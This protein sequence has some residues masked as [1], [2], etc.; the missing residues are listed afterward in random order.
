M[1]LAALLVLAFM[2]GT[3]GCSAVNA[4]NA[5]RT[6]TLRPNSGGDVTQL[7][8]RHN[9]D[10][11]NDCNSLLSQ[12]HGPDPNMNYQMMDD[13]APDYCATHVDEPCTVGYDLYKMSQL[14]PS[15][16]GLI[17][18]VSVHVVACSV[19]C[20]NGN[21]QVGQYPIP[22]WIMIKTH[23]TEYQSRITIQG[24]QDQYATWTSNP[25]TGETWTKQ[26]IDSLQI[27][28][29]LGV[30]GSCQC[31]SPAEVTGSRATQ[32]YAVVSWRS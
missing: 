22:A 12:F 26:E 28:I 15:F 7:W 3:T 27:G 10:N 20:P 1:L 25:Y 18:G 24:W 9:S 8:W 23:G 11:P 29:M 5:V 6:V 4:V 21:I 30:N 13:T 16:S 31:P 17:T 14:P 32:E 19:A 2:V